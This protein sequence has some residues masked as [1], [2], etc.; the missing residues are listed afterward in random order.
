LQPLTGT[1]LLAQAT[2]VLVDNGYKSV[3]TELPGNWSATKARIFEDP[4]SIVAVIVYDTWTE[5]NE[6][7]SDA[8]DTL[9]SVI[10]QYVSKGEAKA[11]EGYVVLMT[12]APIGASVR[13][14]VT[15]IR[16]DTNRV[17]K[18][19]ATGG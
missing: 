8:Q 13:T 3:E 1:D 6:R 4:Y 10:S 5:L 14:D 12:P 19:V 11:W 18:L 17:R 7:W 15:R 9:V 2:Q 16:Y